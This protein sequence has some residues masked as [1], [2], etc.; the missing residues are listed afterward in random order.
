[1]ASSTNLIVRT[2]PAAQVFKYRRACHRILPGLA[3]DKKAKLQ[4][5]KKPRFKNEAFLLNQ[6]SALS[7]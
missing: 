7:A 4:K 5:R 1:A 2:S 6:N 3:A